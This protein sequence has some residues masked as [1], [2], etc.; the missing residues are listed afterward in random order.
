MST[1]NAPTTERQLVDKENSFD[2]RSDEEIQAEVDA[3]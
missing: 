3:K 1:Q 2:S